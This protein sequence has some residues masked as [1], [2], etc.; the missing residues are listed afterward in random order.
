M[1][2]KV[3]G[4]GREFF[5]VGLLKKGNKVVL[6][7]EKRRSGRKNVLRKLLRIPYRRL[8]TGFS[9]CVDSACLLLEF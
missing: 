5:G 2:S 9:V 6:P 4:G 3:G 1:T 7:G 8:K